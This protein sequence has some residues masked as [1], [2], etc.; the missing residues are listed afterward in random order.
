MIANLRVVPG[1]TLLYAVRLLLN[2]QRKRRHIYRII[3]QH[4]WFCAQERVIQIG[5]QDIIRRLGSRKNNIGTIPR[6]CQHLSTLLPLRSCRTDDSD[7]RPWHSSGFQ[8]WNSSAPS[9]SCRSPRK[10]GSTSN[11]LN[12]PGV[13]QAGSFYRSVPNQVHS[14]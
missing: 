12:S 8:I 11:V 13:R 3:S 9:A 1:G 10:I 5:K 4:I 2:N 14:P 6:E 7:R